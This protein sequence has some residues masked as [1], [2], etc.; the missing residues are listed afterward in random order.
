MLGGE[1]QTWNCNTPHHPQPSPLCQVIL[2][3]S[4]IWPTLRLPLKA[5]PTT[6]AK[7][8]LRPLPLTPPQVVVT[9]SDP[10]LAAAMPED[11]TLCRGR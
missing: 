7:A 2:R 9:E 5:S 8:A 3:Q 11:D 6:W 10:T 4:S 1:Q